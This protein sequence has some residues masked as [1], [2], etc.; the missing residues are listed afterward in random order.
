M[1][2]G[3]LFQARDQFGAEFP[4]KWTH[5]TTGKGSDNRLTLTFG[6]NE[7]VNYFL[8]N[9][10]GVP[11][12]HS[13]FFHYRVVDG[14]QEA[15]DAYGGDFW[16]LSWAQEDYDNRFLDAHGLQKGNLYKLINAAFTNDLAADMVN[17]QRYQARS[18]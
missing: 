15:P 14:P 17:Q 5:L 13:V 4:R 8:W 2:K 3:N 6:F 9:K 10:V 12:L 16:G 1:N 18:R 7:V 11:A